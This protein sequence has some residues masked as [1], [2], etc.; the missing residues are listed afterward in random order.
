MSFDRFSGIGWLLICM[1]PIF[2]VQV[3]LHQEVMTLCL[4]IMRKESAASI[5]FFLLFL[6]GIFLHESSHWLTARILKVPVGEFSLKPKMLKDGKIRL[7]YVETAQ[8]D[9]LRDTLIG[10]SPIIFGMI[11]IAWISTA[12]LEMLPAWQ[13]FLDMDIAGLIE[14]L[15]SNL[16]IADFWLWFYIVF[17]ISSMML[18]SPSDRRAWLPVGLV[19]VVIIAVLLAAGAGS[20]LEANLL[21]RIN[22][23]LAGVAMCFWIS[24]V[25][26]FILLV[27]AW[28]I[29]AILSRLIPLY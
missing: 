23:F 7:G 22:T 29:R 25:M 26:H 1:L 14:K 20:W 12:K 2:F 5:L 6:P 13:L 17:S 4:L 24:L 28:I 21:P 10:A 11:L 9:W 8:T 19:I 3:K 15:N 27:P 18:P 16:R